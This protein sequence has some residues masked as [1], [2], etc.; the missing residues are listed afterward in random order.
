MM[1]AVDRPTIRSRPDRSARRR[2]RSFAGWSMAALAVSGVLLSLLL[3]PR[4]LLLWNDSASMAVGFYSVS[5]P[6]VP[7]VGD[8]VI[9]RAPASARRLAAA[10][11]YLPFGVPLVKRVAAIAGDRVCAAQDR[12]LID[13]RT[14]ARRR[15]YDPSGRP[16]PWWSG[17]SDLGPGELLLLSARGADSF[18][19]RYFGATRATE[20]IGRARLLWARPA[21][22]SGHG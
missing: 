4:P 11:H 16:M 17:C 9:A 14:V 3:P 8:I 20:L 15:A 7:R 10:R 19:G 13:G 2:R 18:D 12:I 6:A 5:A 22:G 1:G 21:N